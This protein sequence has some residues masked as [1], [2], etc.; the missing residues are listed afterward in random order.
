MHVWSANWV[1]ISY[2]QKYPIEQYSRVIEIG[3]GAGVASIYCAKTFGADVIAVDAAKEVFP[4][5]YANAAKHGVAIKTLHR[6]IALLTT[7]ELCGTDVLLG[8][9]VS[10]WW[11]I[12]E[13][14]HELLQRARDAGVKRILLADPGRS[15]FYVIV[16]E[17][18]EYI[19]PWYVDGKYRIYGHIY[20]E[21]RTQ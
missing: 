7:D 10:A 9:E 13:P 1:L 19:Y 21:N 4:F 14:M 18:P 3:C 5:L 8:V 6:D 15:T 12:V 2:L 20:D 17:H 11:W 16:S